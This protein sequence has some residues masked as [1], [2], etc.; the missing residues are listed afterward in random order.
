MREQTGLTISACMMVRDEEKN[1]AR[2]LNSIKDIVDEII[3]V[4][5][6][7]KDRTIEIAKEFGA[8]VFI[9]PWQQ[10]FSVHRN[11]SIEHAS[12]D[13]LFIIDAD[14]EFVFEQNYDKKALHSMLTKVSAKNLYCAALTLHD[15]QKTVKIMEF[16]TVRFFKRNHVEYI[17]AVHNQPKVIPD[18]MAGLLKGLVIRHYGYDLTEEENKKKNERS[19]PL[20]LKR[21]E[22]PEDHMVH[23]YLSQY[24]AINGQEEKAIECCKEYINRKE[25]LLQHG[26]NNFNFS[27]YFTLIRLSMKHGDI[28]S[29]KEYL[30]ECIEI[31]NGGNIDTA[32]VAVEYYAAVNDK[33]NVIK[34]TKLFINFCMELRDNPIGRGNTFMFS[35][36][37]E[38][39]AFC[40]YNALLAYMKEMRYMRDIFKI[41]LS[42]C[43]PVFCDGIKADFY[44]KASEEGFQSFADTFVKLPELKNIMPHLKEELAKTYPE[45][46]TQPF[47]DD[48]NYNIV[49]PENKFVVNL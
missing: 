38:S 12:S 33:E 28:T 31:S 20:L 23:F 47:P 30:D 35:N 44:G 18:S 32:R 34:Y 15:I 29:A 8:K 22:D 48:I 16:S 49:T 21:L 6:G 2:C 17:H 45:V 25:V 5:T 40:L 4:D 19:Y 11:Q 10:D 13:W 41:A 3:V 27:V 24:Y 7:S 36:S 46:F 42:K 1:L 26:D 39:M 43:I 37:G 14:E 9:H